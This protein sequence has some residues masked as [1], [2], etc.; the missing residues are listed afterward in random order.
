MSWTVAISIWG[1][2]SETSSPLEPAKQGHSPEGEVW[3][4]ACAQPARRYR[5]GELAEGTPN[6]QGVS[7]GGGNSILQVSH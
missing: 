7:L 5:R 4:T 1:S 2:S 6:A 3:H